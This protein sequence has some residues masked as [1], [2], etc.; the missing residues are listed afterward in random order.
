[1][2]LAINT[3]TLQWGLALLDT[4]GTILAEYFMSSGHG[5]FGI[6]MPALQFLLKTSKTGVQDLEGLV[7]ATGPGSFTGL[8]VGLAAA[9]GLCHGLGV[10]IVGVSSLEALASQ[11]PFPGNPVV[12]VLDSRRGEVF[13]GRFVWSDEETLVRKTQDMTL[14]MMDFPS[15]F[16]E[17]MVLIGNHFQDQALELSKRMGTRCRLAPP[18]CW[19]LKASSV[20]ALGLKRFRVQAFD[21]AET[22]VPLY[23]RPPHIR[24]RPPAP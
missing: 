5:H 23:R 12:A 22:L 18:Q 24:T 10:P 16:E 1:V 13:A 7:V 17:P 8:R 11:V 3:S 20:G 2:I 15:V 9:K 21:T 14:K 19:A 4:Q 6:L